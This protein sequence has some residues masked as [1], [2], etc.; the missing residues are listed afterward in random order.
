MKNVTY[1]NNNFG[2][3]EIIEDKNGEISFGPVKFMAGLVETTPEVSGEDTVSRADN[4]I[5]VIVS[6]VKEEKITLKFLQIDKEYAEIAHGIVEKNGMMTWSK[7]PK[8]HCIFYF[9][10]IQNAIGE[11]TVQITYY[12]DVLT[13]HKPSASKTQDQSIT[14]K[15]F[16][17]DYITKKSDI[18]TDIFDNK[19]VKAVIM[20]TD[21]NKDIFDTYKTKI[22]TPKDLDVV[23]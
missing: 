23:L 13:F 3:A 15:E 19:I 16:M 9:E 11:K 21:Q 22:L 17:Q 1:G 8:N 2:Y 6:G 7:N 18:V 12:Y 10:D 14:I 20:R 4:E 5:H